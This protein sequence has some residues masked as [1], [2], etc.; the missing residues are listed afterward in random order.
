MSSPPKLLTTGEIATILKITPDRVCRILR[1]RPDIKPQALLGHIRVFVPAQLP[2]FR[3]AS[4][5]IDARK[6][7]RNG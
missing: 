1:K 6:G 4:N 2:L 5:A 3:H 7:G